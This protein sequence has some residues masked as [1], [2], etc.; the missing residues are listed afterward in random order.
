MTTAAGRHLAFALYVN[1]VSVAEPGEVKPVVGQAL[2]EIAA[3]VYGA[4]APQPVQ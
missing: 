3:A 2:G 1:N 4:E